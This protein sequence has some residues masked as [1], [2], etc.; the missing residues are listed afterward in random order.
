MK[1]NPWL[2]IPPGDYEGHMSHPDVGQAEVLS[3]ITGDIL[4][5]FQ[6]EHFA[7][8]GC[9][10][11][12]GLEHVRNEITRHIY[13][14]DIQPEYIAIVREKF[15]PLK[16]LH[17]IILDI[18]REELPFQNIDLFHA[19]LVLEY[20]SIEPALRKMS[21][22]LKTSGILSVVI[23]ENINTPHVS[24]TLFTSLTQLNTITKAVDENDL[25]RM[26][27]SY[28]MG[29]IR[30]REMEIRKGKLFRHIIYQKY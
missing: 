19:A 16:G 10:T 1:S 28:G 24:P 21:G 14:I 13:A 12:N 18:D 26:A 5:E 20:V 27:E 15:A 6:P 25:N 7:I 30:C 3:R 2:K 11:G 4:E 29:L 23:Q 8:L 9:S 17:C 22:T